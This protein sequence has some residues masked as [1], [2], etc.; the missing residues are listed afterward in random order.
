MKLTIEDVEK[1]IRDVYLLKDEGIIKLIAG[2]V[3]SNRKYLNDPPIWLI[4]LGGSSAGKTIMLQ[5]ISKCGRWVVPV[6]TLSSNTFLSAAKLDKSSSLLDE[7]RNGV[8]VFKDFTTITSMQE[9][10]LREIMGQ[11]RAIYDGE[12]TKRVGNGNSQTW[13]GKVGILGAGTI[14]VQRKMRQYSKNGER[15]LNYIPDVADAREIGYRAMANQ[16]NIRTKESELATIFGRFITERLADESWMLPD[17]AS[18]EFEKEMVDIAEFCT[19]ARSPVEMNFKNPCI[20]NF[21]GDREIPGRMAMMLKSLGIGIMMACE[22]K[23][24]T[25][26]IAKILYKVALDS[27]PA[28]RKLVLVMLAKYR[29]ASTR[30]IAIR[31]NLTT[32]TVR[33]WLNQVNALKM[34]D[35][36]S[37]EKKNGDMWSMKPQ[38]KELLIEYLG[39]ED[40][41]IE[42]EVTEEEEKANAYVNTLDLSEVPNLETNAPEDKSAAE[43]ALDLEFPTP[44]F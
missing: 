23:K 25:P 42:L 40:E 15:F 32:D 41:D 38:Y 6:D 3:L 36:F 5:L 29:S 43:K 39:I 37:G 20:V 30:N 34:I 9:D 31:M 7:A 18:E 2:F 17:S 27:I 14:D 19:L 11:M 12:F 10:G 21:V 22:E 44:N 35:R 13:T 26:A 28:E 16:K 24:L 33:A 8:L 4:V 1:E